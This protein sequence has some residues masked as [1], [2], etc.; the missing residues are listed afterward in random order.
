MLNDEFEVTSDHEGQ[1]PMLICRH[2]TATPALASPRQEPEQHEHSSRT[3][4]QHLQQQVQWSEQEQV[5]VQHDRQQLHQQQQPAAHT[6]II[7][8]VKTA[9]GSMIMWQPKGH[10]VNV[11]RQPAPLSVQQVNQP[12]TTAAE[13][14]QPFQ[15]RL[16]AAQVQQHCIRHEQLPAR[17][18]PVHHVPNYNASA[19]ADDK[20][21]Q[22]ASVFNR[23]GPSSKADVPVSLPA[24][25]PDPLPPA[26]ATASAASADKPPKSSVFSRV[27]TH[28]HFNDVP[29]AAGAAAADMRHSARDE[30]SNPPA[31]LKRLS[32]AADV[33][34]QPADRVDGPQSM[35]L[36]PIITQEIAN[37]L[38]L[39]LIQVLLQHMRQ[40]KS[41][42]TSGQAQPLEEGELASEPEE[43]PVDG[44][45]AEDQQLI[46]A[47]PHHWMPGHELATAMLRFMPTTDHGDAQSAWLRYM[48]YHEVCHWRKSG[49][50]GSGAGDPGLVQLEV[51]KM[52]ERLLKHK[53][54]KT[55]LDK[56]EEV[57]IDKM[58]IGARY[59][60]QVNVPRLEV[61]AANEV[62]R[63]KV[64]QLRPYLLV[65]GVNHPVGHTGRCR[66][67]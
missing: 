1:E 5:A 37:R 3:D 17:D 46:R 21:S 12:V 9:T 22:A 56:V 23:L 51:P 11:D 32:A 47:L 26:A 59:S 44:T 6:S 4:L 50:S 67:L 27:S 20:P 62:L 64:P 15:P 13:Q 36:P 31:I 8:H 14:Q 7:P 54:L 52:V 30:T 25:A 24:A 57:L 42:G 19:H 39:A 28:I 63:D 34:T 58:R 60:N 29:A 2:P 18:C 65:S 55:V 61:E 49:G 41:A 45:T 40:P 66:P 16:Q 53:I 35:S 10:A 38:D 43:Q 48:L 33:S